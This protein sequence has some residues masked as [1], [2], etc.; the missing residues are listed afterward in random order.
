MT[1]EYL[2]DDEQLEVVKNWLTENGPWLLGG[3]LLGAVLLFGYRYYETHRNSRALQAA[4]LFD[5]MTTA[6]DTHNRAD[7][8][9][10]A[11]EIT[12]HFAGS[13]YADQAELTLARL[14][15]DDGRLAA[16]A[17]EL[18]HVA[19]NSDDGELRKIARVRLARVQIAEGKPDQALAT[20][21]AATSGPFAALFDEARG[22]ALYAKKDRAGAIAQ[23]QLALAASDARYGGAP[24]L[25]LKI[26]DLGAA[27][28]IPGAAPAASAA[29]R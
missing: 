18:S 23:Y 29:A 13:P 22:D 16:A 7:A 21:G 15:V 24:L 17:V 10:I 25:S 2:T 28:A 8:V 3:A 19:T 27:P 1:E 26:A 4:A 20:L 11:G 12:G 5:R 14:A 6:L 9:R